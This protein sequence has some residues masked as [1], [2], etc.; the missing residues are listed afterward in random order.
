QGSRILNSGGESHSANGVSGVGRVSRQQHPPHP[1][2]GGTALV[3]PIRIRTLEL[4][5]LPFRKERR[6]TLGYPC[7]PLLLGEFAAFAVRDAPVVILS[8]EPCDDVP[9][10]AIGH[11]V[12]E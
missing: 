8:I 1:K 9:I 6:I 3:D 5:G 7:A 10:G 4:P 2:A 12:R 11:H